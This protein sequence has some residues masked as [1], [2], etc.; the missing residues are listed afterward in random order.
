VK[1][2]IDELEKR[3]IY[4]VAGIVLLAWGVQ[5]Y[6]AAVKNTHP[7]SN[8]EVIDS[9]QLHLKTG[10]GGD[11]FSETNIG[12]KRD[13]KGMLVVRMVAA[14]YGFYPQRIV[15]P[16]GE[17][18]KLRVASF[19]VLHGL[20][21]P[22]SNVNLMLVPGFISQMTTVLNKT[23]EFPIMCHDF[24]GKGHAYMFGHVKI[25]PANQFKL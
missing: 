13:A 18:F 8:L 11:E 14:R 21:V 2:H 1:F 5:I 7:P 24:C 10:A 15:L 20:Y 12:V 22:M 19:D 9:A 4:M 25:V 17:P 16:Q 3:W 23:G 6:F